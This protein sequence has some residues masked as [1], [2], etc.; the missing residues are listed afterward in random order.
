MRLI[1]GFNHASR[2]EL[3]VGGKRIGNVPPDARDIG[4]VFQSYALWP[5]MSVWDNVAFGLV[6]RRVARRRKLRERVRRLST[7]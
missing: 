2:G 6:E 5:H 7:W 3:L 4:M 1:A